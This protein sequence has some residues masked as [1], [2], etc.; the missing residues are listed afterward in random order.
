MDVDIPQL[1]VS[2]LILQEM[3]YFL[4]LFVEQVSHCAQNLDRL[5]KHYFL[6]F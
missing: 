5:P 2:E 6:V 4:Q 3:Q 1:Y